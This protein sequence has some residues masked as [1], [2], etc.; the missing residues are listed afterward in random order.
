MN[1]I[2]AMAKQAHFARSGC[3]AAVTT[4]WNTENLHR[5]PRANYD[6]EPSSQGHTDQQAVEIVNVFDLTLLPTPTKGFI[7][8]KSGL[9]EA[10][11]A[12]E[13]D[14]MPMGMDIT[15]QTERGFVAT[16]PIARFINRSLGIRPN[17]I[18]FSPN[19]FLLEHRS[20]RHCDFRRILD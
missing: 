11:A 2:E 1:G 3:C 6:D 16:A 12:I 9:D 13:M 20:R 19:V 10:S 5:F 14:Q 4:G 8:A 18:F 15:N 7:V 17:L